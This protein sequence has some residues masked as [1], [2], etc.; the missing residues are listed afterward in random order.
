MCTQAHTQHTQCARTHT[1]AHTL[2]MYANAKNL[3]CDV[4]YTQLLKDIFYIISHAYSVVP[5]GFLYYIFFLID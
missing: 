2:T 1:H 5:C 3:L 4:T